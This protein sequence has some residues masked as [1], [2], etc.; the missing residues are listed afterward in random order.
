VL[1]S[2][3]ASVRQTARI[4]LNVRVPSEIDTASLEP[5]LLNY[6]LSMSEG[7]AVVTAQILDLVEKEIREIVH[8]REYIASEISEA[9][10][11]L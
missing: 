6:R 4:H 8:R 9:R 7:M 11:Q 1:P 3:A 10:I 2:G 5:F